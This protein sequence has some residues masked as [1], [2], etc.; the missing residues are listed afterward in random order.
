MVSE[1]AQHA[2]VCSHVCLPPHQV[3]S[4]LQYLVFFESRLERQRTTRVGKA[5]EQR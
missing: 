4:L 5:V 1:L 3:L 2:G